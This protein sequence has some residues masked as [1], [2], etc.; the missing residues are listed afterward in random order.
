MVRALRVYSETLPYDVVTQPKT[1]ALLASRSLEVVLAVR[2]WQL[3][4][5]GGAARALRDAGIPLSVWPMISDEEGRWASAQN[6]GAFVR[7]VRTVADALDANG[8]PPR[9]L[10]ID[11]EP[12]F[13][14]ARALASANVGGQSSRA[15]LAAAEARREKAETLFG[16]ASAE[17]AGA[18]RELHDRGIAT[19]S[20]VW[21]LVALDPP[22][23]RGWQALLGTPVDALAT[24]R[25]SVMMYTSIL[26]G[27][28]RGAL[29]RRDVA[30]LLARA[31]VRAVRRWDARAG[32]SVGCVG[33]GAF[34][35]EPTYRDPSELAEDVALV[36]AA[37]CEDL[38]L[39]DLGGV[40]ARPPAEAWLDAFVHGAEPGGHV[41]SKRVAAARRLAR[42]ATWALGR[43]R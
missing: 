14:Q 24:G 41:T 9:E 17:L 37:G 7:F 35:D 33:T 32:V 15:V 43:R 4:P 10:L 42:V 8:V 22:D 36:R 20:A 34:E 29:R 21:P 18:V 2:P 16:R 13:A 39:F 6:A 12:P 40:L 1:L 3:A 26:E 11:L 23:G 28:S 19:S 31:T 27:W 30:A 25:V 38:S 5:L